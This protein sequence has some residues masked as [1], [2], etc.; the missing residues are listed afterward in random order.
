MTET[1]VF[2]FELEI[3]GANWYK[4]LFVTSFCFGVWDYSVKTQEDVKRAE[5]SAREKA[6]ALCDEWSEETG[7][8]AS[9]RVFWRGDARPHVTDANEFAN[10]ENLGQGDWT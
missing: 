10:S 5:A 6:S 3:R 2:D 8:P 9:A 1:K 4:S 7:V